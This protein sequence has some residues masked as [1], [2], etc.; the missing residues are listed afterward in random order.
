MDV[1]LGLDIQGLPG[2]EYVFLN[3]ETGVYLYH[4][5]E[6]LLNTETADSGY[7][8]IIDRIKADGG[9]Q[10]GTYA[11]EDEN[12]V[13]QMVVYKYLKDCGWV[14]M[15]RDNAAARYARLW[16]WQWSSSW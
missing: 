7:L 9:T 13:E 14:F 1:L 16:Q 5:N 3:V 11:Y 8:E 2:S 10:A 6:E 12:G 15:V 4:E